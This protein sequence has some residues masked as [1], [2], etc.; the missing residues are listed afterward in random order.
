MIN[1]K[2]NVN[3]QVLAVFMAHWQIVTVTLLSLIC[4]S[5]NEMIFFQVELK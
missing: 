5:D 3:A 4:F 1:I 2:K